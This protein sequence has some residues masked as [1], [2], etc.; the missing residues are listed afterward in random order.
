[1][2][3][4]GE[5]EDGNW[6]GEVMQLLFIC[7]VGDVNCRAGLIVDLITFPEKFSQKKSKIT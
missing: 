7:T 2:R 4:G 3:E 5:E 6:E 1:M